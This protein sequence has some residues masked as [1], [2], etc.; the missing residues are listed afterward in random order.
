M[1]KNMG[2]ARLHAM[3]LTEFALI[4]KVKKMRQSMD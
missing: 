3:S 2:I 4:V 1:R